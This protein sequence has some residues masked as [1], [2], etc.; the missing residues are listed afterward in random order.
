MSEVRLADNLIS[1]D[2]DEPRLREQIAAE[3]EEAV[4]D[5]QPGIILEGEVADGH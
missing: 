5:A 3:T 2:W 4:L 1:S